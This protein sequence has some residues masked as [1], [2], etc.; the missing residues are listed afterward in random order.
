MSDGNR[1]KAVIRAHLD[2]KSVVEL[3]DLL[4]NLLQ[5]ADERMVAGF[6]DEMALPT[7]DTAEL[8]YDSPES[9]LGELK[10]FAEDVQECKY[11][12][13]EIQEQ[14]D[15]YHHYDHHEEDDGFDTDSHEGV[16]LLRW[17]L[18]EAD[19][20]FQARRYD[21]VSQAYGILQHVIFAD[22]YE[23][24]GIN[25]LFE[26]LEPSEKVFVQRYLVS[27]RQS[28]AK[29]AFY[30]KALD[31][32][33]WR[34]AFTRQYTP[35]FFELVGDEQETLAAYLEE[36]A[37]QLE[38]RRPLLRD[39]PL[40]LRLL[41]DFYL[42]NKQPEKVLAVQHRFRRSYLGIFVPLLAMCEAAQ[43][44]QTLIDYGQELLP[45]M[46]SKLR[47][48][49]RDVVNLDVVRTQ[50]AK[51]YEGLG[52]AEEAFA[53]YHP[54][55]EQ[56]K[57]FEHYALAQ[58]FATAISP[59]RGEAFSSETIT[60]LEKQLPAGRYMLCE[61]YLSRG[62]FE[63][64]YR[65]VEQL[66]RYTNLE[67]MKLVAKAHLIFGLGKEITP[68]MGHYLQDLYRKVQEG[69]KEAVRFLRD[70]LPSDAS[71]GG[72]QA[73]PR[74]LAIQRAET[75]YRRIMQMHIDNG[76]KT[77]AVAA[78]YCALLAEIAKHEGKGS[79]FKDFYDDLLARYPRHRALRRE[80]TVRVR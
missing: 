49:H 48:Y 45:L 77:Y 38:A 42:E 21:V 46:P 26:V 30:D 65:L 34:D 76:R 78:Y 6:W 32:L 22:S 25:D 56:D 41:M 55:F 8:L 36:W 14:Y 40:R 73:Y 47:R 27:L 80:L 7:L 60:E 16:R 3:T 10:E 4:G 11:F 1:N 13:L 20:Y 19:C 59:Q 64:A 43:D 5:G 75:L 33:S 61:I 37:D 70:H 15:L 44:W 31:F 63:K 71:F 28:H 53:I 52:Q 67:E 69:N 57:I 17:F 9:F 79:E 66:T 18:K 12:D 50:M 24:L 68:K 58:R 35:Y 29:R 62:D 54:I 39:A 74:E 2:G 72:T 23:L 51:A